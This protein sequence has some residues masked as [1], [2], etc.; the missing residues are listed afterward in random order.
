M[1]RSW[2]KTVCTY[3]QRW[4]DKERNSSC[5]RWRW[6]MHLHSNNYRDYQILITDTFAILWSELVSQG[7]YCC[8]LPALPCP[9]IIPFHPKATPKKPMFYNQVKQI[10]FVVTPD[11]GKY[12]FPGQHNLL[13]ISC[14]R[15]N[16]PGNLR[17]RSFTTLQSWNNSQ[18]CH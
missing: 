12:L 15:C 4:A 17:S 11:H 13:Y 10:P 5:N 7:V 3:Q 6:I 8:Y 18:G 1:H 16:N 14:Y 9:C 2:K